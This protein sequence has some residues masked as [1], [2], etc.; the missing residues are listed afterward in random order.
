MSKI[1]WWK[2]THGEWFVVA[3]VA[4]IGLVFF[5]F[6]SRREEQW[7]KAKFPG[8]GEYQKRVRKLIPSLIGYFT[9]TRGAAER[10]IAAQGVFRVEPFWQAVS[11]YPASGCGESK[12]RS[13]LNRTWELRR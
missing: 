6:K 3:Q 7:L 10:L 4:L 9:C 2:G 1:P 5:D 13:C 8:Y 12:L 11:T